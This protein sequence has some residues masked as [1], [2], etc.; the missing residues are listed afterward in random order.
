MKIAL[1][2]LRNVISFKKRLRN[3]ISFKISFKDLKTKE[4][5]YLYAGDIPQNGLY[6]KFIGL[7]LSQANSQHIKHDVTKKLPLRDS[8]VDIYQSEDVFEYIEP[9]KLVFI[10]NEIY[11]VLKPSG[12]FRLSM[13]DY[14]CDILYNRTL[15]RGNGELMFDPGGGGDFIDGKVIEGHL[16]F[17]NYKTVK[18]LLEKTQFDDIRFYHYYDESGKGVTKPI[19]YTVGHVNRTPDHDNRVKRPYR[20]MSIVVDCIK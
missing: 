1:K 6:N 16:W 13:P 10:I 7:S 11:R 8:C 15:K 3:I 17:P 9:E 12:I 20:P 19:D 4:A 2:H 5:I 18:E 14:Q